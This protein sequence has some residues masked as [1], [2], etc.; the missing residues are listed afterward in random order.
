MLAQ[1][2]IDVTDRGPKGATPERLCILSRE[3]KAVGELI[4]FVV[5][6]DG[7]VVPD[8]KRKLPGR[9]VWVTASREALAQAVKRRLFAKSFKKDVRADDELVRQTESLLERAA[10]DS[11]SIAAKARQAIC[12]FARV[13]AAL[14]EGDVVA[15]IHAHDGA[16]DGIRKLTGLWRRQQEEMSREIR[17]IDAFSSAQLD[18]ALG[19]SNVVHAALLAGEASSGFLARIERYQRFRTGKAGDPE[20]AKTRHQDAQGL[21]TE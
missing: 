2:D 7:S 14:G 8:I 19:R 1:L 13:E 18:L 3:P 11:L 10:L 20:H 9:G 6:P 12:G 15:L 21:G 4:R 16:D 5:A 17:M